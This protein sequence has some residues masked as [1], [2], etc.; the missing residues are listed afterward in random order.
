MEELLKKNVGKKNV[1]P[2]PV[3]NLTRHKYKVETGKKTYTF[4]NRTELCKNIGVSNKRA[5]K[6]IDGEIQDNIKIS[7]I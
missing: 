4:K 3:N 2:K 1:A 7:L 6:I 5:K